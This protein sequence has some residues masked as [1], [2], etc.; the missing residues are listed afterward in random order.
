MEPTP[1]TAD[2][3]KCKV[4]RPLLWWLVLSMLLLTWQF[5]R[6][7]E[8]QASI[9]FAVLLEGR[10]ARPAYRAELN[11]VLFDSGRH[12]GLWHKK[13]TIQ[14]Q[15]AE[16]FTTNVFVWYGGKNLGNIKLTRSRGTLDLSTKPS[17]FRVSVNGSETNCNFHDTL[18]ESLPLPTGR[19]QVTAAFARFA[20]NTEV[21][22]LANQTSHLLFDPGITTLQL[23]SQ[24][25]NAEF[26]LR[27][28]AVPD[29]SIH[30]N[31]PV[32]LTDLPS[33][34]YQLRIWRGDYQKTMPLK[35]NRAL[36]TNEL[37]VEFD[38]AQLAITS[39]PA[40]AL[41][42]EGDNLVG[43]TPTNLTLPAGFHRLEVTK[44]GFRA[45]NFSL[46]LEANEN[47][48]LAVVLPSLAYLEA[49]EQARNHLS[50]AFPDLNRAQESLDK[51][52]Q[53]E[54]NDP[55]ALRLKQTIVFQRHLR[56]AREL[57]R[58][59][60]FWK[61]NTEV[62]EALKISAADAEALALKS[63]LEKDMQSAA[64]A[65]A[66]ARREQP[67]KIFQ[68][69]VS[70]L[71]HSELFPSQKMEFTGQIGAARAALVRALEKNP[72]WNIRQNVTEDEDTASIQ[73]DIRGLASRQAV[74]LVVA[75][76]ADNTI[77]VHFK[78][79]LYSLGSNIHIGLTGISEDSYKPMHSFFATPASA[80]SVEHRRTRDLQEFRKRLEVEL[81]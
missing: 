20:T 40:G 74:Y 53:I 71:K 16:P 67:A 38:Y 8:Q 18:H 39:K 43:T 80:A 62:D 63:D 12:S 73:A 42:T 34:E 27:S 55:T 7:Q 25:T 11:D 19:Y 1:P 81:R 37:S 56:D 29:I 21:E 78:L 70:H 17:A 5:H 75:Q 10:A 3:S 60:V 13:L 36:G 59:G 69:R 31:T 30:N 15:D 2:S 68:E 72:S 48:S 22:I 41:I 46:T 54:P 79:F 77:E 51:A 47:R 65:K 14:A 9:D 23:N 44:D 28:V 58:T 35:L 6:R 24:P 33:G 66:T 49:I 76:T 4:L 52:L 64:Q 61:A 50:G 32:V 26:D 45:T 57:R